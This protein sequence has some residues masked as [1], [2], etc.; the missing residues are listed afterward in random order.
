M[1]KWVA[2]NFVGGA[3]LAPNTDFPLPGE[4]GPAAMVKVYQD[5]QLK[6]NDVIEVYG[7]LSADPSLSLLSRCGFVFLLYPPD[8][9]IAQW[10]STE[11]PTVRAWVQIS[12]VA[13]FPCEHELLIL[14]LPQDKNK[15]RHEVEC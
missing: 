9:R 8:S 1:L 2:F 7:V 14:I 6:L 12:V 13:G 11:V 10:Q 5:V 15:S 4:T 3:G